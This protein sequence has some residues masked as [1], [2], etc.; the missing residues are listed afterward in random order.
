MLIHV[1]R[2][3]RDQSRSYANPDR[4]LVY[5]GRVSVT[6]ERSAAERVGEPSRHWT[7]HSGLPATFAHVAKLADHGMVVGRLP[8]VIGQKQKSF[9]G[10]RE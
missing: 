4:F 9:T 8:P 10:Q 1:K 3:F 5:Q 6:D 2:H 7:A